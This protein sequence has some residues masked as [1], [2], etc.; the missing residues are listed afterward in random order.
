MGSRIVGKFKY[1][2]VLV[3]LL[4]SAIATTILISNNSSIESHNLYGLEG[5]RRNDFLQDFD[6]MLAELE[7]SFPFFDLMKRSQGIDFRELATQ[8]RRVIARSP[9]NM[10]ALDFYDILANELFYH[11]NPRGT[12][13]HWAGVGHLRLYGLRHIIS[14]MSWHLLDIQAEIDLDPYSTPFAAWHYS[15]RQDFTR[16]EAI[17]FFSAL[18]YREN[19]E[20]FMPSM[21]AFNGMVGFPDNGYI[22]LK[23]LEVSK[24]AYFGFRSGM[25]SMSHIS[26]PWY[27]EAVRQIREFY[28]KVDN[29]KHLIIDLRGNSGGHTHFFT[30]YILAPLLNANNSAGSTPSWAHSHTDLAQFA[31]HLI[32]YRY[33]Y[34]HSYVFYSETQNNMRHT[35][36]ASHGYTIMPELI[37]PPNMNSNDF[38]Q[39][40][41]AKI[42]NWQVRGTSTPRLE[43]ARIWVLVNEETASGAEQVSLLMKSAGIATLVGDNT[44][45]IPT[46][47]GSANFR[48]GFSLPNTG[49]YIGFDFGYLTDRYGNVFE[50]YGITPHYFNRPGIDALETVLAM[51]AEMD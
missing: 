48:G 51:I 20:L 50:G 9:R 21:P 1:I 42:T 31:D 22:E 40:D 10:C 30:S 43:N 41:T 49:I 39:F 4:F 19:G 24:I 23:S 15:R 8:T 13:G 29:Y 25:T 11:I 2:L 28:E 32:Q 6:Y 12:D 37:K 38:E 46:T 33:I 45:G 35:S 3:A 27:N 17:S 5:L 26:S 18:Y 34:L 44:F 16:P 36:R 47:A 14:D 7:A